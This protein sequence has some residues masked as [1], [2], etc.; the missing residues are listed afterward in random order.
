MTV[1]V[2]LESPSDQQWQFQQAP[3]ISS[4]QDQRVAITAQQYLQAKRGQ[5][6]PTV[7]DY[8]KA[9]I[10]ANSQDKLEEAGYYFSVALRLEPDNC[11]FLYMRAQIHEKQGHLEDAAKDLEGI[12]RQAD[13]RP[14]SFGNPNLSAFELG[15]IHKAASI[16]LRLGNYPQAASR[17]MKGLHHDPNSVA[18]LTLS[19]QFQAK[20]IR[21]IQP[22]VALQPILPSPP[23]STETSQASHS[24]ESMGEEDFCKVQ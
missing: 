21:P 23:A 3:S 13:Q 18:F 2:K 5:N 12:I 16:Y 15:A 11:D 9:G 7:E 4:P 20:Q 6:D 8:Y 10:I 22:V 17:I 24:T 19:A 14:D 1:R